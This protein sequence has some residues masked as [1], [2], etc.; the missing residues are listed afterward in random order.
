M[1][2]Y[3]FYENDNRVKRYAEALARRGT[4]SMSSP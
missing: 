1:V 2:A 3:T 4:K